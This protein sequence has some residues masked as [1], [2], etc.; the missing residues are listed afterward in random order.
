MSTLLKIVMGALAF[1]LVLL[2][3]PM[4]AWP[5]IPVEVFHAVSNTFSWIWSFND[6]IPIDVMF[7]LAWTVVFIE[8]SL[9]GLKFAGHIIELL[10]GNPTMLT[11]IGT[12][13]TQYADDKGNSGSIRVNNQSYSK[14]NRRRL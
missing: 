12:R 3:I 8:L 6:L 13:T 11:S 7:R 14:V 10:T 4:F 5:D 2:L 1:M 9:V